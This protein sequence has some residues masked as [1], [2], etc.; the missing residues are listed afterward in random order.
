MSNGSSEAEWECDALFPEDTFEDTASENVVLTEPLA[1]ANTTF[2]FGCHSLVLVQRQSKISTKVWRGAL[3]CTRALLNNVF[4]LEGMRVLELGAGVGLCGMVASLLGA[5]QVVLTDCSYDSLQGMLANV[6]RNRHDNRVLSS[7]SWGVDGDL[8]CIQRHLWENDIV[9]SPGRPLPQH[10][11]SA[12]S[13][14]WGPEG[15]PPN[16]PVDSV[17]DVVIGSD[18][19]YF[20]SQITPLLSTLSTRM[21]PGGRA[22]L[23]VCVRRNRAV[24]ESFLLGISQVALTLV[25]EEAIAIDD[26]DLVHAAS[27]VSETRHAQE[28]R[29]VHLTKS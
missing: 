18:L 24:Y 17:F 21:K 7:A 20:A 16:L 29:L 8:V 12:T 11:S 6:V 23:A 15:M 25:N 10:W 28:L 4:A 27:N 22:L 1:N 2:T 26:L 5:R 14:A 9:R 13:C 3:V 19:L